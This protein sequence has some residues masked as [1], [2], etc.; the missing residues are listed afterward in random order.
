MNQQKYVT[1]NPLSFM[2]I[3]H[4]AVYKINMP[5]VWNWNFISKFKTLCLYTIV[6][7]NAEP[8]IN[9]KMLCEVNRRPKVFI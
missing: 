8:R 4:V 5:L 3:K 1:L 6:L 9:Y 7:L 2:K